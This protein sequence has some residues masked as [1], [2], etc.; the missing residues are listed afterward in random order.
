MDDLDR[1]GCSHRGAARSD[2]TCSRARR[3]S[4]HGIQSLACRE[5]TRDSRGPL[6]AE[7]RRG[8]D[9]A[10]ERSCEILGLG[11]RVRPSTRGVGTTLRTDRPLPSHRDSAS[12]HRGMDGVLRRAH[13]V[14]SSSARSASDWHWRRHCRG[15]RPLCVLRLL[16]VVRCR[17]A[18]QRTN[19]VSSQDREEDAGNGGK[20]SRDR[21]ELDLRHIDDTHRVAQGVRHVSQ[22]HGNAQGT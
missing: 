8:M 10:M 5:S 12:G 21:P 14:D 2:S 16:P 4:A 9:S 20:R 22:R 1:L 7:I 11:V 6:R 19:D 17:L 15:C 3:G 13:L 18:T